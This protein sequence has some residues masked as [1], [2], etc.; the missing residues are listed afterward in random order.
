[1]V[2]LD[3][4]SYLIKL[5][6][7]E[8]ALQPVGRPAAPTPRDEPMPTEVP[9]PPVQT[10]LAGCIVHRD[11]PAGAPEAYIKINGRLFLALL[12]SGSVISLV[13]SDVLAPHGET[14]A[15]LPITCVHGDMRHV[16]ARRVT[17]SAA[18]GTWPVELVVVK[19]LPVPVLLGMDWPGFDCLLATTEQPVSPRGSRRRKRPVRGARLAGLGQQERWWVPSTSS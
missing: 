7:P 13:Q 19:D 15:S 16:P 3:P 10:W 8:G 2:E 12:D 4:Q 18:L 6:V 5:L 9:T 14:K 17:I 11:L 1:M